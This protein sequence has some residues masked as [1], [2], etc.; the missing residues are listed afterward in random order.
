MQI[1]AVEVQRGEDLVQ[2]LAKVLLVSDRN[3]AR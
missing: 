2:P 1:D 3:V